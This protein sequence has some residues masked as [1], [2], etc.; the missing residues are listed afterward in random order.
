M[1]DWDSGVY[2]VQF[3]S[4]ATGSVSFTVNSYEQNGK[5]L[6]SCTCPSANVYSGELLT[7]TL[8][9]AQDGSVTCSAL[10]P[11][12]ANLP[13]I[14]TIKP[15]GTVTPSNAP[16]SVSGSTYTLTS[17]FDGQILVQD[18]GTSANPVVV[19]G[20]FKTLSGVGGGTGVEISGSYVTLEKLNVTGFAN[21]VTMDTGT[22]GNNLLFNNMTSNSIYGIQLLGSTDNVINQNNVTLNGVGIYLDSGSFVNTLTR[23]NVTSNKNSGIHLDGTVGTTLS[24]NKIW[25]SVSG[26][27][28]SD[29]DLTTITG[30][31]VRVNTYGINL[32]GSQLHH[33][34]PEQ[35]V[36]KQ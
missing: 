5:V 23:N 33:N 35:R 17:N 26:V 20:N 36:P 10:T 31:D 24:A 9:V 30:N 29:A 1:S 27:L 19:D 6:G 8:T 2:I 3:Y 28:L 7:A 15:D 32:G 25:G 4:T 13:Q 12:G 14:I 18:S 16:I 22:M 21:G 11:V 34:N